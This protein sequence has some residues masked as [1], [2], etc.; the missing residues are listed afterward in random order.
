MSST[1]FFLECLALKGYMY[2]L[3][4]QRAAKMTAIT[5]NTILACMLPLTFI[6]LFS[7]LA[8][9]MVY[10]NHEY[11]HNP[12]LQNYVCN[13]NDVTFNIKLDSRIMCSS[14]CAQTNDC[15]S[16]MYSDSENTCIGCRGKY[17]A[18]QMN[19]VTGFQ[20]YG[21]VTSRYQSNFNISN[22]LGTMEIC[23]RHG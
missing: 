8:S 3:M 17:T 16:F 6:S 19:S 18:S 23:S 20:Y 15:R 12:N 22:I 7:H 14:K 11:G 13:S 4:T 2:R 1:Q 21:D 5:A 9:G 10:P